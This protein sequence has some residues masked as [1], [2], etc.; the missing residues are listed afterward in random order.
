MMKH[1]LTIAGSDSGGGAGI[2]ADLKTITMLQA[3]GASVI[4]AVTA[5]NT[6][7]V[8]GVYAV[9]LEGIAAQLDAVC[10]DIVFHGVKTGM[11]ASKA[12]VELVSEK[13]RQYQLPNLVVDPVMV[14]T[15]GDM[16]LQM[17]AVEAL[18]QQLLPC[19][20]LVTPNLQEAEVLAEQKIHTLDDMKTAGARILRETGCAN[21][22]VKGGHLAEGATDLLCMGDGQFIPF[23][24]DRIATKNSHGTGCTLSAALAT[25]LGQGMALPDAVQA[26]KTYLTKA[27]YYG[28]LDEIGHGSGPV[29]HNYALWEENCRETAEGRC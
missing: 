3:Y 7:G 23:A 16:L 1:I 11:L 29:R 14:A 27:L 17:D 26:A 12:V 13:L 8:R 24:G 22:L 6:V 20:F 4:T 18:R 19:A 2:Q 5:Q 9:P 10:Q 15:S 28:R 25:C 21:V